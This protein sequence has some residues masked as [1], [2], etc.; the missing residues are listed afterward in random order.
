MA[1]SSKRKWSA[2]EGRYITPPREN[3]PETD[4]RRDRPTGT[5]SVSGKKLTPEEEH[6]LLVQGKRD[7]AAIKSGLTSEEK[8]QAKL[9][10]EIMEQ[11]MRQDY[12]NKFRQAN[13]D[14]ME[15]NK[16]VNEGLLEM[17][18]DVSDYQ[19]L[20][21]EEITPTGEAK[22]SVLSKVLGSLFER[23][24][25]VSPESAM[26]TL[27][28][29]IQPL[30][31]EMMTKGAITAGGLAL[32]SL[33]PT[34]AAAKAGATERVFN[35]ATMKYITKPSTIASASASIRAASIFSKVT[36]LRSI[37]TLGGGALLLT[38]VSSQARSILSESLSAMDKLI[39]NVKLGD[40][41]M[42][43]E[44]ARSY[45]IS[46]E[47]DINAARNRVKMMTSEPTGII[48]FLSGGGVALK[49]F[50]IAEREYIPSK[51]AALNRAAQEGQL[52]KL[53]KLRQEAGY[54][55]MPAQ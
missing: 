36:S 45:M 30:Q 46:H 4:Y 25:K 31:E 55:V 15:Y 23:I 40:D 6:E 44:E 32:T 54:G 10:R 13:I 33:L 29:D 51:W 14:E 18:K 34:A 35:G 37:T 47:Q 7:I 48:S 39:A 9:D 28:G 12:G 38:K 3:L 16:L 50:E 2:I 11:Q 42:T 26:A 19:E 1:K 5:L 27:G 20:F 43:Y 17:G 41:V 24:T 21:T 53:N 49:E 52:I 22:P 8:I